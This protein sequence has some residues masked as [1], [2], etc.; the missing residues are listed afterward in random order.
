VDPAA[1]LA[2]AAFL[3][4]ARAVC[5][6]FD[7]DVA[8]RSFQPVGVPAM[9]VDNREARHERR[10]AEL[11]ADAD[12]LWAGILGSLGSSAPR[13][14]LIVNHLNPLIRKIAD[15]ADPALSE[16]AIESLY[17]QALLL[18]RRPLRPAD[19]ALLNRSFIGLLE[20]AA[21]A[22]ATAATG[23]VAGAGGAGGGSGGGD[24]GTAA[25]TASDARGD[26]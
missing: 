8:L 3:A 2:A 23:N 9:L 18:S 1:E 13:A 20:F 19:H 24:H 5:D 12:E 11:S 26:L 25:G 4:R 6:K 10:R 22:A 14:Q 15:I 17:G 16:T 7:T 21:A